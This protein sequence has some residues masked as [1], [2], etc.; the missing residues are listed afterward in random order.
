MAGPYGFLLVSGCGQQGPWRY[1]GR[2]MMQPAA[3]ATDAP[4]APRTAAT[5]QTRARAAR[6]RLLAALPWLLLA[7]AAVVPYASNL[8]DY[9]LSDDLG[10]VWLFHDKP[11]GDFLGMFAG[12]WTEGIYGVQADELRPLIA[13][14]YRLGAVFGAAN[15]LGYHGINL[16]LHVASTLLVYCLGVLTTR[17]QGISLAAGLLFA[18]LPGHAEAVTWISGSADV[19]PG[20]FFLATVVTFVL[21]RRRGQRRW[22]LASLA[23]F[24]LALFTKQSAILVPL[25]L[26]GYDVLLGDGGRRAH[27]GQRP[28][29]AGGVSATWGVHAPYLA[30]VLGYLLLR[31]ALFGQALRER[32]WSLDLLGQFFG[33]QPAYIWSLFLPDD[34]AYTLQ[35][36]PERIPWAVGTALVLVAAS[37][38]AIGELVRDRG[39]RE[40]SL[41]LLLFFGPLWHGVALVPLV[42]AYFSPRHLYF[43]SAGACLLLPFL[44][45]TPPRRSPRQVVA[46]A[47][48]VVLLTA[49][50]AELLRANGVWQTAAQLVQGST[51]DLETLATRLPA[52]SRV[53]LDLPPLHYVTKAWEFGLPFGLEPPF[54]GQGLYERWQIVEHPEAYCCRR[55][56][57]A[58]RL[59]RIDAWAA[60]PAGSEIHVLGWRAEE[61]WVVARTL[62]VPAALGEHATLLRTLV[63]D[64]GQPLYD[65]A[66]EL[67]GLLS[68][69]SP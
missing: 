13:L 68:G 63:P 14:F 23:V 1:D 30:L 17:R 3:A 7:A 66:L 64:G 12:D 20:F 33:R 47:L 31:L 6:R 10:L 45:F 22:Y 29:H 67:F 54:M 15:P 11:W 16:T 38:L 48:L 41:R 27:R 24:A 19:I 8:N 34:P 69:G 52:G 65:A 25:L 9:F 59:D 57:A 4:A 58:D 28:W 36:S 62:E 37:A 44:W 2:R 5:D 60:L 43:A 55:S 61:G 50:G 42:V 39:G 46:G 40:E 18:L 51:R 53:V 21:F 32:A 26:V 35:V 56:W 49:H